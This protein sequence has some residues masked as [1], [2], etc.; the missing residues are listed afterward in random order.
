MSKLMTEKSS[1]PF[2]SLFGQK[3]QVMGDVLVRG[4]GLFCCH[5][6]FSWTS[7]NFSRPMRT[8]RK[9]DPRPCEPAPPKKPKT[10]RCRPSIAS[11]TTFIVFNTTT[12]TTI[13]TADLGSLADKERAY[14][15]LRIRRSLPCQ[16]PAVPSPDSRAL[17]MPPPNTADS[18]AR[19]SA[20][21]QLTSAQSTVTA[22]WPSTT[23]RASRRGFGRSIAITA[24]PS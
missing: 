18:A 24:F 16:S 5:L 4:R 3:R 7:P 11:G 22:T 12:N 23:L 10:W 8:R 2:G 17:L 15:A 13:T 19:E 20:S 21:A 9:R 1:R 14:R 6:T